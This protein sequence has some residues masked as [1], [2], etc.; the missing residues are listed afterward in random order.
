[1]GELEAFGT[2]Q[3]DMIW[4]V[5]G[6]VLLNLAFA[7]WAARRVRAHGLRLDEHDRAIVKLRSRHVALSDRIS[8]AHAEIR[9]RQTIAPPAPAL[10]KKPH[11]R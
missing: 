11:R 5:A 3:R 2:N 9:V 10:T 1:M 6:L 8:E 4:L 7:W